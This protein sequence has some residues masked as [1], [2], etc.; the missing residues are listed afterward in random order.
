MRPSLILGTGFSNGDF[1][2]VCI[3]LRGGGGASC[4]RCMTNETGDLPEAQNKR[5]YIWPWFALG[6]VLLAIA[7]AVAWMSKEIERTRRLRDW[8]APVPS[9]DGG[10][11]IVPRR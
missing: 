6:A 2:L 8:N 4:G 7:L 5:R 10:A 9:G 3:V 1:A 11:R